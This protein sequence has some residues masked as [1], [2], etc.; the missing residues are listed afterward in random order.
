[1]RRR[2]LAILI[3]LF[4]PAPCLAAGPVDGELGVVWWANDLDL[5]PTGEFDAGAWG[6]Y[7]GVWLND[8]WG[9]RAAF[10]R[11]DLDEPG[12]DQNIDYLSVD[13]K[14]RLVSVSENNFIAAGLGWENIDFGDGGDS[15]GLRLVLD[16][17][18]GL[19]RLIFVYGQAA[20]LP[21]MSDADNRSDLDAFEIEA[22]LGITPF[23]FLDL[24]GGYRQFRLDFKTDGVEDSATSKGLF[25][26]A[27]VHF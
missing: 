5:D 15:D 19:G 27:G 16:G 8:R 23:P 1:M 25:I 12:L 18:F 14:G 21:V 20:W 10:F 11:S 9:A 22:G 3:T 13:V 7:A 2:L 26:G 24:R 17:R 6:G 4:S